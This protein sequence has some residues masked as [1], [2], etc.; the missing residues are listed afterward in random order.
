M[1]PSRD[2]RKTSLRA[3]I[4]L[5]GISLL[6]CLF[7]AEI[8]MRVF[9]PYNLGATGHWA[10]PNTEKYGW[11]FNPGAKVRIL[12]PDTGD[13]YV[14]KLNRQGWQD[15]DHEFLKPKRVFRVLVIGDSVT[16]GAIVPPDTIYPRVLER[17][18]QKAGYNVEV[19]SM[20][21]GG[22]GTD[23]QLEA[24]KLEGIK[25][26]PDLVINQ[27]TSNDLSDNLFYKQNSNR[28]NKPFAYHLEKGEAVRR[29][30]K[31]FHK[32]EGPKDWLKQQFQN[33]EILK[34]GYGLYLSQAMK[35]VPI[36]EFAY[37]QSH[38]QAARQFFVGKNQ[39]RHLEIIMKEMNQLQV[40]E[41]FKLLENPT[42]TEEQIQGLLDKAEYQGDKEVVLRIL[43]KRWFKDYWNPENYLTTS[44]PVN[45]TEGW[46]LYFGILRHM[47]AT[48]NKYKIPLAILCE[49][50]QKS[51]EWSTDWYMVPRTE[52]AKENDRKYYQFIKDFGEEI[53][54]ATIPQTRP[55]FRARNDPH[56]NSKGHQ[57]I[58]MDIK[59]Y[60][61]E[62]FGD[63][64]PKVTT[65][66]N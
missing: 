41:H 25:Y 23:Q 40:L 10:A 57:S 17:E 4:L 3:R 34:R 13:L 2:N 11:G 33:S 59:D 16:F 32:T 47:K 66:K 49:V 7:F 36:A 24:L 48:C 19:I 43:E 64:L 37:D 58:A 55:Y 65:G 5:L 15:R 18:M 42:I 9:I 56:P 31:D 50:D 28:R 6:L 39:L 38:I 61:L 27:F 63:Q 44:T 54:Y 53:G 22:W 29:K 51:Y 21:Y 26:Q 62:E 1:E 12:D 46:Q 8:L 14:Y 45:T 52:Q 35:E 60:L 30:E 20:G